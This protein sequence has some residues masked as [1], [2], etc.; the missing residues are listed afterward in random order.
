MNVRTRKRFWLSGS[1]LSMLLV[2]APLYAATQSAESLLKDMKMALEPAKASTRTMTFTVHSTSFKESTKIVAQQARRAS[3]G[4]AA[5]VTVVVSPE[6]LKGVT[7]LVQER[8]GDSNL[9]SVY[10]P[11]F[12][13]VR[14]FSGVGAFESFLGTD[15]TYADLGLVD[16]RERTLKLL[17]PKEHDGA[18]AY[19]LQET[20]KNTSYYA[21]IVDRIDAATGLPLERDHYD[22]GN[23]LWRKQIYQDVATIDGVLTPM[24]VRIED[25][26]SGDWSE[27]VVNDLHY[28][29]QVPEA[30]F[31]AQKLVEVSSNPL[32]SVK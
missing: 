22:V 15:F 21:R 32:W 2:T 29:V 4:A 27:L 6:S 19:E 31:D 10:Y 1:V 28:D 24:K 16:V 17:G 3:P 30:V 14:S 25:V 23:A 5:S 20:P 13:R 9:V 26:Q 12:K 8:K 7:V 11:A 18:E